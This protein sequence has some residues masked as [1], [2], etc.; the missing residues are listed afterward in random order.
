MIPG[1]DHQSS[2][3]C[4]M[5]RGG[6]TVVQ[7]QFHGDVD[8]NRRYQ[9]YI[10]GFGS[11]SGDHWLGLDKIHALTTIPGTTLS[12]RIDFEL[13][14]GTR[15]HQLYA[16]VSVDTAA[17]GYMLHVT[18][19]PRDLST[20]NLYNAPTS[21]YTGGLY[22]N[23]GHQFST[24]DHD[25][26]G[27]QCPVSITFGGGGGWWFAYCSFINPNARYG[28]QYIG[29]ITMSAGSGAYGISYVTNTQISV[30]RN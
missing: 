25:V 28:V 23:N 8:F 3:Y 7:R 29:G 1:D 24:I 5:T 13:Y 22:V 30:R 6:W 26:D 11:V 27:H 9:D 15:G 16:D 14:N 12:L 4:D 18:G 20:L 17:S 19:T 2:V 21:S 10:N